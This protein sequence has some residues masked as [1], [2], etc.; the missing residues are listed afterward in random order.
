MNRTRLQTCF[1]PVLKMQREQ[2]VVATSK[3]YIE[4]ICH[5]TSVMDE[6]DR[7]AYLKHMGYEQY[8]SR[9]VLPGGK[10][11][12]IPATTG[13]VGNAGGH[14]Q[15]FVK[16]QQT[17]STQIETAPE[18]PN[19]A[20]KRP[21]AIAA[22]GPS[23]RESAQDMP[24]LVEAVK[25]EAGNEQASNKELRFSVQFFFVNSQLAVINE[26]PHEAR[27]RES[28][29]ATLLLKNLIGALGFR[30]EEF[31]NLAV[32]TFNW[33]IAKGL[34]TTVDP[35]RAANLALNGFIFQRHEQKE[36]H[37]LLLLTVQLAD[38]MSDQTE[39][40]E[41]GDQN[42]SHA[43]FKLTVSHSLHAMLVHPELKREAWQHL[44]GLRQRIQSV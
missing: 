44:A 2:V 29:Q 22:F 30:Q 14:K 19:G 1:V 32:D 10:A 13:N 20:V 4:D 15:S 36:F 24:E 28:Q 41:M 40:S 35:R 25:V 5:G 26:S 16:T 43:Q 7:I 34:G 33:P 31:A 18:V 38:L 37:N 23:T 11:S 17:G 12:V 3:E 6:A 21:P 39:R 8:F 9:Y 27:G 42:T